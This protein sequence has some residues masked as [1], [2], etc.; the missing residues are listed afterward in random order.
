[1]DVLLTGGGSKSGAEFT[2]NLTD[3]GHKVTVL[4]HS[5]FE[6]PG[7]NV[8]PTDWYTL[9]L[10]D[11]YKEP[12][13]E[14]K[15]YLA[16]PYD[17]ILFWHNSQDSFVDELS[18]NQFTYGDFKGKIDHHL[19]SEL[20]NTFLPFFIVKCLKPYFTEYTKIGYIG[21]GIIHDTKPELLKYWGYKSKK[22]S[23]IAQMKAFSNS[24]PGIFFG[25]QPYNFKDGDVLRH[26][27][28]I[29]RTIEFLEPKHNGLYVGRNFV[30]NSNAIFPTEL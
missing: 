22:Y 21:S 11:F 26:V 7:V 14:V 15:E 6:Y 2:K 10:D 23:W 17:L 29:R 3:H 27:N 28:Q 16:K 30:D 18:K 20:V 5:E 12:F 4:T 1:L 9:N 25:I 13:G 24:L 19:Q 8:I